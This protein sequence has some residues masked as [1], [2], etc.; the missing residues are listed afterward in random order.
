MSYLLNKSAKGCVV[1]QASRPSSPTV[2]TVSV[3]A[4]AFIRSCSYGCGRFALQ[5][6][7]TAFGDQVL[8]RGTKPQP[9][10]TI[11]WRN[12]LQ[13]SPSQVFPTKWT[14]RLA[15]YGS[16]NWKESPRFCYTPLLAAHDSIRLVT[17]HPPTQD[18]R[19]NVTLFDTELS[20]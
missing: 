2:D 17:I 8:L 3:L 15:G 6:S 10:T 9:W 11:C 13:P 19:I 5:E 12:R 18:G 7:P 4:R 14:A 16:Q 1:P 20:Q